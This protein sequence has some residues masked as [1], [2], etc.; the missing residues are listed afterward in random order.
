MPNKKIVNK[1]LG[2]LLIERGVITPKQ[3]EEALELQKDKGGLIGELLVS[4]TFTTEEEIAKALTTQYGFAYLPLANYELDRQLIKIIPE[5]VAR[6]YCL[7]PVDKIANTLSI[8]MSNPLNEQAVE[9]V[10]TITGC[11]VQIFV[12]TSADIKQALE[13]YYKE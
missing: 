7:L 12:S 10:E 13:T 8:A 1:R 2:D 6:Q 9:D 4:L 3:L 5:R 11:S